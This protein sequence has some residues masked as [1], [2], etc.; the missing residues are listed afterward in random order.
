MFG[1]LFRALWPCQATPRKARRRAA[2]GQWPGALRSPAAQGSCAMVRKFTSHLRVEEL[3]PRVALSTF[4]VAPTGS[5]TAGDGSLTHPW[6]TV[7]HGL[8]AMA[9]G[10]TLY[11]RGGTYRETATSALQPKSGL[12]WSQPTIRTPKPRKS[13]M[14]MARVEVQRIVPSLRTI[15]NSAS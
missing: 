15:R 7:S 9:G 14:T 4:Y 1:N 10:D 11:L 12:S 13:R 2:S 6:Q 8:S 5:D 3:E